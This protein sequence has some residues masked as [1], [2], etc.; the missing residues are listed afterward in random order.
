MTKKQQTK[1][2]QLMTSVAL[3]VALVG[4]AMVTL[5]AVSRPTSTASQAYQSSEAQ[6]YNRVR[7]MGGK[8]YWPD[9]CRGKLASRVCADVVT[10]LNEQEVATYNMWVSMGKPMLPGKNCGSIPPVSLP[11]GTPRSTPKATG[12]AV[13]KAPARNPLSR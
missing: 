6:C 9:A 7:V 10:P 11:L 12:S 3:A 13:Q 1:T 8:L 5:R 2:V 4:G